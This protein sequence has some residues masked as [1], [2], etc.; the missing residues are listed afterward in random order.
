MRPAFGL[1]VPVLRGQTLR[2]ARGAPSVRCGGLGFRLLRIR[3]LRFLLVLV[4][5]WFLLVLIL[6]WILLVLVLKL[7]LRIIEGLF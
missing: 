2:G 1:L 3:L 6:L 7:V 5:L 4:L